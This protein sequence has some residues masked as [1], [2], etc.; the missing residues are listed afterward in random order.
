MRAAGRTP[1]SQTEALE[2]LAR[3]FASSYPLPLA[4]VLRCRARPVRP[5]SHEPEKRISGVLSAAGGA[6]LRRLHAPTPSPHQ[7]FGPFDAFCPLSLIGSVRGAARGLPVTEALVPYPLP[8][9]PCPCLP[10]PS[11][12]ASRPPSPQSG[13]RTCLPR[14]RR[15]K[16]YPLSPRPYP[17]SPMPYPQSPAPLSPDHA[18]HREVPQRTRRVAETDPVPSRLPDRRARRNGDG[19][20]PL[21]CVRIVQE[22]RDVA[23]EERGVRLR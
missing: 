13:S 7:A 10:R 22:A 2:A 17:L 5:R 8:L 4:P 15:G 9:A 19:R 16:P 14:L 3:V 6:P 1:L 12:S 11:P 23:G 20:R 18:S 21:E